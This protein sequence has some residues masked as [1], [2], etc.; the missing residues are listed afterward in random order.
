M[1]LRPRDNVQ[2]KCTELVVIRARIG[3]PLMY[4][5]IYILIRRTMMHEQISEDR[6]TYFHSLMAHCRQVRW[7]Y[8][9]AQKGGTILKRY[10]MQGHR[11][12]EGFGGWSP[13]P[14][15]K[16]QQEQ[17]YIIIIN[18]YSKLESIAKLIAS[19]CLF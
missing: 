18:C 6:Q 12:V 2:A 17:Y 15:Q 1:S 5:D 4:N 7:L 8:N 10:S 16:Q 3:P 13:L 11:E 14:L 9:A 19:L